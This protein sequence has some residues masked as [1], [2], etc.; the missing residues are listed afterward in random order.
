M[1]YTSPKAPGAARSG[2]W[3]AMVTTGLTTATLCTLG[4][5]GP[6]LAVSPPMSTGPALASGEPLLYGYT[7]D[8]VDLTVPPGTQGIFFQATGGSGGDASIGA[9]GGLGALTTGAIL[10][11]PGDEIALAVGQAG[12]TGA[13]GWGAGQWFGGVPGTP[14]LSDSSGPV[15]AGGGGGATSI[16]VNDEFVTI[17]G[18]GGG[19]GG[20]GFITDGGPNHPAGGDGGAGGQAAGAGE[21]GT[22][23]SGDDQGDRAGGAGGQGGGSATASGGAGSAAS[24]ANGQTWGQG[25]GGGGGVPLGGAGGGTASTSQAYASGGGGGGAGES[26]LAAA[27]FDSS[28]DTAPTAGD[29]SI[30]IYWLTNITI[31]AS[32]P[33]GTL[34]AS[35]T[36]VPLTVTATDDNGDTLPDPSAFVTWA[37]SE[38][39]DI[40]EGSSIVMT[41][42]VERTLTAT[43]IGDPSVSSSVTATLYPGPL[44]GFQIVETPTTVTP[45]TA[46]PVIV[47]GVDA[48]GN[49][50]GDATSSVFYS[51]NIPSDVFST[52]AS[53]T[54]TM[55]AL[56]EHVITASFGSYEPGS[57][58][59]DVV[60]LGLG[61]LPPPG[62]PSDGS[63][64]SQPAAGSA[65]ASDPRGQLAETGSDSLSIGGI[66]AAALLLGVLVLRRRRVTRAGK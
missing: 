18:G 17:A 39:T 51:S 59:I 16:R 8:E 64:A 34:T 41:K 13:P 60:A 62:A 26:T 54:V 44:T 40:I 42:A 12:L 29:G 31:S 4:L 47:E 38:P 50:H 36:P 21:A 32:I 19:A 20:S 55:T 25:G 7:G 6:A 56:G 1:P 24:S 58:T 48:W 35:E 23:P 46:V 45:G 61:E 9:K 10:V 30:E 37:S 11:S 49:P 15:A 57:I 53:N 5:A 33:D 28:I 43:W 52:T 66:G 22:S 2:R 27:A 65:H 3:V 14:G 63:G